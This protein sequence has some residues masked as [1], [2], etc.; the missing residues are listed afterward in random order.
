MF[1][2]SSPNINK[3]KNKNKKK[4]TPSEKV[5]K[6]IR[7][8]EHD[9]KSNIDLEKKDQK[10]RERSNVSQFSI[11]GHSN[12]ERSN[13]D[14][15]NIQKKT[16]N[17]VLSPHDSVFEA[18]K[19]PDLNKGIDLGNINSYSFSNPSQSISNMNLS[20]IHQSQFQFQ[21]SHTANDNNR[22]N[23]EEITDKNNLDFSITSWQNVSSYWNQNFDEEESRSNSR[24]SQFP[25]NMISNNNSNIISSGNNSPYF[26][27]DHSF[28]DNSSPIRIDSPNVASILSSSSG[29]D[30]DDK[31]LSDNSIPKSNQI[32]NSK[33]KSSTNHKNSK[34]HNISTKDKITSENATFSLDSDLDLESDTEVDR[35]VD[36]STIISS[37]VMP[38]VSILSTSNSLSDQMNAKLNVRIIGDKTNCLM[39]RFK[40][41][42]K[43]F[44][45]IQF[46]T[47]KSEYA[48]L[49]ILIVNSDN[50]MLPK[51]TKSPCI[52]ITLN[53]S[54]ILF[55][56]KIPKHL[57]LCDPIQLNSLND[58][59]LTL[60]D[61]LSNINDL[62][63]WRMFLTNLSNS[64]ITITNSNIN[65]NVDHINTLT[66]INSSLIAFHT[67]KKLNSSNSIFVSK[68][69]K[70]FD[71]DESLNK[72]FYL[73][74]GFTV[75]LLSLGLIILWKK[76]C[77]KD[78]LQK[79]S[80][81]LSTTFSYAST[82]LINPNNL[83]ITMEQS[84]IIKIRDIVEGIE[85]CAQI[86][87]SQSIVILQKARLA[88]S[89]LL[90]F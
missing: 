5:L 43:I 60:I 83:E 59:L 24:N 52:P 64:N 81:E 50:Y 41:Y 73:I 2:A 13:K 29:H 77:S 69:I 53:E 44:N 90:H 55:S 26:R 35:T 27:N 37:F 19:N 71:K 30:D 40:S 45:N 7:K 89:E 1:A 78:L 51:M 54:A 68:S 36:S 31:Y 3:N 63:T 65:V 34:L 9:F 79:S 25:F 4:I 75:G 14:T 46:Y 11:E 87:F 72:K 88:L 32:L 67:E 20:N 10:E 38:R 58:D 12:L 22:A 74:T 61:F 84:I 66:D 48:D 8:R 62:K 15:V 17:S 42:K 39:T 56:K 82:D 21:F 86:I 76:L 85:S 16:S 28:N 18:L 23:S 57:K 70:S 33:N 6:E 49:L 47:N 80:K